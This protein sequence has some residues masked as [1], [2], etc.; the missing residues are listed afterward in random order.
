MVP[1]LVEFVAATPDHSRFGFTMRMGVW[2]FVLRRQ[3]CYDVQVVVV[4]VV[5]GVVMVLLLL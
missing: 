3:G 1:Q 2:F 4:R 5:V